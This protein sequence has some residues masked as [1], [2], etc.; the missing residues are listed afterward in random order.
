M[1]RAAK[2]SN[3]TDVFHY[4]RT[5]TPPGTTGPLLPDD[6]LIDHIPSRTLRH[7]TIRLSGEDEW[8]VIAEKLGSTP[9]EIRFLGIRERNPMQTVL[10]FV[11]GRRLTTVGTLYDYINE[12]GLPV[13]ADLL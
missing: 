8:K 5:I 9:E 2:H 4:L 12:S 1:A 13:V 3:R 10:S 7:L 6:M 11:R